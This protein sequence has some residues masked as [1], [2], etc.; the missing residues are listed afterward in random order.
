MPSRQI[1]QPKSSGWVLNLKKWL[2]HHNHLGKRFQAHGQVLVQVR[3]W[4]EAVSGLPAAWG[5]LDRISP[6]HIPVV[7]TRVAALELAVD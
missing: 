5:E 2:S 7:W 1:K 6:S 3:V 4:A